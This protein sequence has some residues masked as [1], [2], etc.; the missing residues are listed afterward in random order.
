MFES[1]IVHEVKIVNGRVIPDKID[2]WNSFLKSCSDEEKYQI[3]I[4]KKKRKATSSQFKYYYGAI[5]RSTVMKTTNY[6]GWE[7][8]EIDDYFRSV[9]AF[10]Y[11]VGKNNEPIK[12]NDEL[13]F[14]STEEMSLFIELV[15][16]HLAEEGIDVLPEG[17]YDLDSNYTNNLSF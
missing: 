17:S 2:L 6:A 12:K 4:K 9:Y 3:I 8:Q 11:I 5:I 7:F 13:K 1:D 10:G 15:I 14:Y 16:K